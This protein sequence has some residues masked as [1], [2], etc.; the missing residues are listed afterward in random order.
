MGAFQPLSEKYDVKTVVQMH[1]GP[2]LHSRCANS[3]LLLKDFDPEYTGL[4]LDLGHLAVVYDCYEM[5]LDIVREYIAHV[6]IKAPRWRQ[7]PEAEK[8][9]KA[10]SKLVVDW[11]P[12]E[13][14]LVPW[15]RALQGL[16][17]VGYS[18]PLA[19][20]TEYER[21]DRAKQKEF[22]KQDVEFIR[23]LL[24]E[25]RPGGEEENYEK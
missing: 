4:I 18:G 15:K 14:G 11:V 19:F 9:E 22:L 24:A 10:G 5:D 17:Y 20:C 25:M 3:Y 1:S 6:M 21:T 13:Q 12:L 23:K 8:A 2:L 7:E 16:E